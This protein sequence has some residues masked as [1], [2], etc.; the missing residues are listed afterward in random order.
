M[1]LLILFKLNMIHLINGFEGGLPASV[2]SSALG[3]WPSGA[4]PP[5]WWPLGKLVSV[6]GLLAAAQQQL[7]LELLVEKK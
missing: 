2:K 1:Y 3:G 5:F 6:A 4:P 7:P